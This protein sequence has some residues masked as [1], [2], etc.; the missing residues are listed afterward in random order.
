MGMNV[1]HRITVYLLRAV[2]HVRE[3]DKRVG[4]VT[5]VV[6]NERISPLELRARSGSVCVFMSIVPRWRRVYG[7]TGAGRSIFLPNL[8]LLA[9]M[10]LYARPS[11]LLA[12]SASQ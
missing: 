12:V 8:I 6:A 10:S 5:T 7:D 9:P 11:T 2:L 3:I 1:Q 4:S